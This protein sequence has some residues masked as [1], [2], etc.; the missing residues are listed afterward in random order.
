MRAI[1]LIFL[2]IWRVIICAILTVL[3]QIGG[4]VYCFHLLLYRFYPKKLQWTALRFLHFCFWYGLVSIFLV[5]F[6]AQFG[7]REP[8]PW[9]TTNYLQPVNLLTCILNRHYVRHELATVT[10][11][12][13][14]DFQKDYPGSVI[15][16]LES[17]FPFIDGFPLWPHLS[18]ND[19]K[20]LDLA[21][22]YADSRKYTATNEVPSWLGYGICEEPRKGEPDR[23]ALC[24][25]KGFWQYSFVKTLTPQM[26]KSKFMFDEK[27]TRRLMEHLIEQPA[28]GKILLE[29]HLKERL[30]LQH[31]KV[32]LHGCN[33]VRHDDHVHIQLK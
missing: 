14:H 6:L 29:P 8:L 20:K 32:R 33:A 5:P 13:A 2:I 17:G 16:Y 15:N 22:C 12:I 19:G 28:I 24:A 9:R 7:G 18:H 31:D 27:R 30:G 10:F 21:F 26:G 4:L 3:S 25:A 1:R 23:P 11:L